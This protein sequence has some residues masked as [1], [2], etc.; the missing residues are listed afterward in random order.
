MRHLARR[1]R[2]TNTGY[3]L[4]ATRCRLAFPHKIY[5]PTNR[6]R[7]G[8]RPHLKGGNMADFRQENHNGRVSTTT[9]SVYNRSHNDREFDIS[10]AEN[11]NPDM[12]RQN[13]II[14]YDAHNNPTIIDSTDPNRVTID[15]HEHAIYEELFQESLA[16]QHARNNAARHPE[17]NKTVD[18]LLNHKNYCPEE[19]IFQIGSLRD[20]YPDPRILMDIFDDFQRELI[21]RY[22]N[23]LHF[24]D[25]ILHM[26]EAIPH[27][28]IR[29]VWTYHGKDGLDISQNKALEEMGFE[30]PNPEKGINKWNNAKITFSEMERNLKLRICEDHG[31]SVEHTPLHPG[32][33]T[34]EKEE[35]IALKLQEEN[36]EYREE[37]DRL[38]D[39]REEKIASLDATIEKK[40]SKLEKV[41]AEL[42][43]EE[44][45]NKAVAD[46]NIFGKPKMITVTPQEYRSWQKSAETK[47]SNKAALAKIAD[48]K[49]RLLEYKALLD[50]REQKLDMREAS[51]EIIINRKVEECIR[52]QLPDAIKEEKQTL[53]S[54]KR[55]LTLKEKKLEEKES[56]LDT[57]ESELDNQSLDLRKKKENLNNAQLQINAKSKALDQ[58][59]KDIDKT[60][61]RK[62]EE[63]IKEKL[64]HFF[65]KFL[66]PIFKQFEA[67]HQS[68]VL[69]I[70]D[71][72]MI[73]PLLHR[74]YIKSVIQTWKDI[75]L[76]MLS[77][78]QKN[79][80]FLIYSNIMHQI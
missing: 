32:K 25:A 10:R 76:R 22:G 27:I 54:R 48:E 60:I 15:A 62:V 40:E 18:D 52:E 2:Q 79:V 1:M 67:K 53:S 80:T 7:K 14:H 57:R 51:M 43:T 47:E 13:I 37:T 38:I 8:N 9:G 69:S 66:M 61:Q 63:I 19:T 26:D 6:K 21:G 72:Q 49:G 64:S 35:A 34:M 33:A 59:E 75:P 74:N 39:E 44:M 77:I 23:N 4:D 31:L 45:K 78:S 70:L 5:R 42:V 71:Q 20:G 24:L 65:N 58:R 17:R 68:E 11:I 3:F 36:Q 30:R 55:T 29:K 12:I 73:D 41:S 46:T 50:K 28:H 16:N 56:L